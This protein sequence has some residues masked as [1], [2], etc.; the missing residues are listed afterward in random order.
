MLPANCALERLQ[1]FRRRVGVVL[2]QNA[3]PQVRADFLDARR[4]VALA[5]E[6]RQ[7]SHEW[8]AEALGGWLA[9]H[10]VTQA[11]VAGVHIGTRA[12]KEATLWAT[13]SN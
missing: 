5:R 9:Q 13:L 11:G 3:P 8:P 7:R 1:L 6:R 4:W 2:E 12:Y 10:A